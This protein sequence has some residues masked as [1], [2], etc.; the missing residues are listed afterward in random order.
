MKSNEYTCA[1]CNN[2][3]EKGWSDEEALKEAV[4]VN[5]EKDEYHEPMA[6]ICDDC[7][8]DHFLPIKK[9]NNQC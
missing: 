1:Y 9:R 6:M 5:F 4:E 7:Y 3:Y 2:T 8:K